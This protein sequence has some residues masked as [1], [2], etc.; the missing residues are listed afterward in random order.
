MV[1]VEVLAGID[2]NP[3]RATGGRRDVPTNQETFRQ[4]S[5]AGY[6]RPQLCRRGWV[7][8]NG[9]WDFASD[10]E[11]AGLRERWFEPGAEISAFDMTITVPFPPG[12][13]LSG[14]RTD[15]PGSV[16]DVVWYRR[17]ITPE[18]LAAA[19]D[20][21]DVLLNFEAV[22]YVADIWVNGHRAGSHRG[23]YSSFSVSLGSDRSAP[24]TV[25]VRAE[26]ARD[27]LSQPRGK[28]AWQPE[29]VAI[30]Y[31]RSTGIWR[32]VWLEAV[33]ATYITSL[34]W[35]TDLNRGTVV[36]EASFSSPVKTGA[37]LSVSLS[38]D[39]SPIA[40]ASGT[41]VGRY[42]RVLLH[43]PQLLNRMEWSGWLWSPQHPNLL[44]A[45]ITLGVGDESDEIF[46]YTGLRTVDVSPR[47]I[48]INRTPTYLRGILDQGYWEQSFYTAPS[49]EALRADVQLIKDLGFNLSRVHQRTADRRYLTWADRLGVLVW[50]ETAAAYRFDDEAFQI[51][52]AEWTDIVIRDRAAPSIVGWVPFN[53]S[54]ALPQIAD[55]TRQQQF[56][57]GVVALTRTLDP[58]R[59]ISANDGWEQLD[60]DMVTV[61]DYGVTGPELIANYE[62]VEA[63][64]RTLNGIGPQGR[65]TV[66]GEPW[67][68]DRP[69]MI[70][71]F[72]GISMRLG[73]GSAWGYNVVETP[74]EYQTTLAE[75]IGAILASP[76]L[77]GFCYTQLTDT[78]PETN[79]LCTVDREPKIPVDEIRRIVADRESMSTQGRP[80]ILTDVPKGNMP[81]KL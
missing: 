6:P 28:Q 73:G 14:V 13:E 34:N 31:E 45:T 40:T 42:G 54:W 53:E 63:V 25:V 23:G 1:T 17:V 61:H 47:Y 81:L 26:D 52:V 21:V 48:S 67:N 69:V 7:D 2:A 5:D 68:D 44:D 65:R 20:G 76:I 38:R 39:G 66:I 55:D 78:G 15:S 60:T 77:A 8:L 19:G 27:G 50:G 11:N 16:P 41:V 9:P 32:D 35:E 29:P 10:E 75:V 70:T 62:S 71:E 80:R 46:S 33:P 64:A 49:N 72:G 57:R 4:W 37:V 56:V 79:G 36:L 30:W 74:E 12:S 18:E 3:V 24:V 59:P 58:S 22:D 43:L 51:T